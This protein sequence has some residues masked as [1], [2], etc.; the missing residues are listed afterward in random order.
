MKKSALLILGLTA[1]L[2]SACDKKS[3]DTI[4]VGEF[5]SLTGKEATFGISSHEG[6]QLAVEELNAAGGVLGKKIKLL[7]EDNQS[8]PG[9]SANAVNKLIAKDGVVAILGEVASSRSLEAAPICQRDGVPQISP[10][11]TNPKVTETGDY[12]FR[13]CFIDPFQGTV[14]AN[15]AKKTLKAQ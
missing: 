10:S 7:T 8:K 4:L 12:I 2:F 1:V 13:V 5:A 15:F 14:M 11:S 3:A 6:T 9:E